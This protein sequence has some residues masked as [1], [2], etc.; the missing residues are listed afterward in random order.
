MKCR[1][2]AL[3]MQKAA[4]RK[5]ELT[6]VKSMKSHIKGYYL[7]VHSKGVIRGGVEML[8][9]SDEVELYEDISKANVLG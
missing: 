6:V 4:R 9:S 2:Q 8:A 1:T 5:F 7:Y 3:K